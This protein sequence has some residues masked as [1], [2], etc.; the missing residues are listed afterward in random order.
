MDWIYLARRRDELGVLMNT[1]MKLWV[2]QRAGNVFTSSAN[3]CI[4]KWYHLSSVTKMLSLNETSTSYWKSFSGNLKVLPGLSPCT[5]FTRQSLSWCSS[6]GKVIIHSSS[7]GVPF[8]ARTSPLQA[9]S[10]QRELYY[11]PGGSEREA[12]HSLPSPTSQVMNTWRFDPC[13]FTS[14]KR[15]A[16]SERKLNI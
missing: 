2:P 8:P 13:S 11:F 15:G 3:S 9:H 16:Q 7:T 6:V 12:D 14:S 5:E 10:E 1:V 4:S